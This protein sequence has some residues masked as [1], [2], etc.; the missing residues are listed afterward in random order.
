MHFHSR[1]GY[2]VVIPVVF[3]DMSLVGVMPLVLEV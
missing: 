2:S 3:T 1:H